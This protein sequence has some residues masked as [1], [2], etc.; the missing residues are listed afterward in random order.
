MTTRLVIT[1]LLLSNSAFAT[2]SIVAVDTVTGEVGA[3]AASC[4]ANCLIIDDVMV[5]IG[6]INTESFYMPG[7]QAYAHRL[8][9]A[10]VS[11]EAIVDSLV[12]HDVNSNPSIR[13]YGIVDLASGGFA[14]Y[15]GDNCS[16]WAGHRV[17]PNY[18]IQGNILLSEAIVDT[19]EWAFLNTAGSLDQKLMAVLEAAKTPGA[20]TRCVNTGRSA[21]SA[22]IR[23]ARPQESLD[24]LYLDLYVPNTTGNTDPIDLLHEQYDEWQEAQR[25][26]ADP[27]RSH[28]RIGRDSLLANGRDTT[29]I[30]IQLL[31]NR[32]EPLVETI[33]PRVSSSLS[34]LM[35]IPTYGGNG[36]WALT[37][38]SPVIIGTDT[39]SVTTPSTESAKVLYDRPIVILCKEIVK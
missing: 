37:L 21:I 2:F 5:G 17:G 16:D 18:A 24:D 11:P 1:L 32:G 8:M 14:A 34:A 25:V 31:N 35:S 29:R 9:V 27:M 22:F 30:R 38:T 7:N 28:V 19:M 6:A 15:T 3:A 12:A 10:G 23:V 13:Q 39:I 33:K 26:I 36:Y 20:D 4:I